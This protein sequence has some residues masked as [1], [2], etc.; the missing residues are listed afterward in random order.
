MS[1]IPSFVLSPTKQAAGDVLEAPALTLHQVAK[2]VYRMLV[3]AEQTQTS[4][5]V[6]YM[7]VR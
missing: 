6:N 4:K 2:Y 5:L 1:V 7:N 3:Q